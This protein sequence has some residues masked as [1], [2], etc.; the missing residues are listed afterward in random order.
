MIKI[1]R[2]V[3]AMK[4]G[5]PL[6][7]A[8]F[9]L[10]AV[11]GA[12]ANED[13]GAVAV[14]T[15]ADGTILCRTHRE[16]PWH[17]V[18][19]D[20]KLAGNQLL[21]G[22]PGAALDSADGAVRLT[23][24]ADLDRLSKFPIAESAVRLSSSSGANLDLTLDRG[25]IKLENRKTDGVSKARVHVRQETWDLT[26][27]SPGTEVALELYGHWLPGVP[28]KKD[29]GPQDVPTAA[30]IFIVVRGEVTLGHDDTELALRAPPGPALIEWDSVSGE[31]PSPTRM[32]ALP[33]WANVDGEDS[34]LAKQKKAVMEK[35]RLSIL[36]KGI[37]ATLEEFV[38]SDNAYERALAIKAMGAL[39]DLERLGTALR[40]SKNQ[41][42]WD[43]GVLTLRHWIGRAP[44]QDQIL[45]HGLISR[46]K[47]T[48]I[49]AETVMQLLHS[50][51]ES[52][53]ARPETFE[54][55]I[56]YL[57]HKKLA[58][59][60]LAYWHLRRLVP[61]GKAFGYNAWD[62]EEKRQEAINKWKNLIPSGK[63]PPRHNAS[64]E[65]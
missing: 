5:L 14:S 6:A 54:T 19:K 20:E 39:D 23:F 48:P 65:K 21:V 40:E 16:Q 7:A 62:S 8:A 61:A 63:L 34:A 13:A 33:A 56:D 15:G 32:D 47:F 17:I 60:G 11:V 24:L 46:G 53:L 31:D 4:T 3:R 28:F 42:D 58:I 50:F 27:A 36:S 22:L 37:A 64:P 1:C 41:D 44:G 35:L 10:L 12:K 2:L 52:D 30:L 59:R 25:R 57:G 55:L 49:D 29:P 43:T 38:A 9:S 26:L 18:R 45:H 51:G